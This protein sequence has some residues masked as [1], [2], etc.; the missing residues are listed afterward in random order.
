MS[1]EPL[2]M[3]YPVVQWYTARLL[4]ILECILVFQ[5]QSINLTNEYDNKDTPKWGKLFIEVPRYFKI[6]G[7]KFD[8]VLKLK[9][10]LYDISKATNLWYENFRNVL[11]DHFFVMVNVYP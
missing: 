9:K 10:I 1:Y 8:I 2:N 3:Y 11:V 6:T 5:S 4:L 7:G